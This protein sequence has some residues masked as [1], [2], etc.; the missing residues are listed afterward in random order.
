MPTLEFV[1]AIVRHGLTFGGGI[2]V[3]NGYLTT[4]E[5]TGAIGAITTLVG[6][7]WSFW[8]KWKRM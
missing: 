1:L 7:V 2:I 4:D 6:L 8:R 3:S 5:V